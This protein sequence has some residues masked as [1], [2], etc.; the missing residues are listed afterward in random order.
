[1]KTVV[2]ITSLV[3]FILSACGGGEQKKDT[4]DWNQKKSTE[5]NKEIAVEEELQIS[6]Y[7]EQHKDLLMEKSGTGLRYFIYQQTN[8]RQAKEGCSAQVE[9]LVTL[10]DGKVCYQTDKDKYEEFV[11]DRSDVETGLQEGI[12]KMKVGERAKLIVPSHIAHGLLGDMDK[13]PPLSPIVI[14]VHL[15]GLAP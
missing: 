1:M 10:L 13:I 6:L 9:L 15:I 2:V 3:L 11:I 7:L 4:I 12:K 14:D 8:G 5:F